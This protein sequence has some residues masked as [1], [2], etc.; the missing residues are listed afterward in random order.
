[1]SQTTRAFQINRQGKQHRA[2]LVDL[3]VTDPKPGQVQIAVEY[4]SVNYKDALAGTGKGAILRQFPLI[5]GIDLAGVVSHSADPRYSEGDGV[6]VTGCGLSETLDGGYTQI[7]TVDADHLVALPQGLTS[8]EAMAMGTA[9]FTAGLCLERMQALGQSPEMGP[10]VVTGASGGVGSMALQI[11]S[12]AGYDV[13]AITGKLK[14]FDYLI[15]L[16]AK[17]CLSRHDLYWGQR[18]LETHRWAGAVDTV[19][20][21]MLAGL[22]RVIAPWGNIACCGLAAGPE[23]HTTVMPLI[24]RGVSLIGINSAGCPMN[25]R[26]KIWQ[27]LASDLKPPLLDRIATREVG[28]EQLQEVFTLILEGDSTGRTVVNPRR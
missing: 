21:E 1:M 17:Q 20:D 16:G 28:L 11:F 14:R 5:G 15:D 4:S 12:Q 2:E 10:I 8:W 26:Q 6:L 9:G 3:P 24:I 25:L 18:P 23:L 22:S 7:A 27:K 13:H 19:G